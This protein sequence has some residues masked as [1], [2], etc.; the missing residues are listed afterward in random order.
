MLLKCFKRLSNWPSNFLKHS[1]VTSFICG[2]LNYKAVSANNENFCLINNLY[3]Y[4]TIHVGALLWFRGK[5][6]RERKLI[7]S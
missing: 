7:Y 4:R 5:H 1:L 2:M 3:V 6:K